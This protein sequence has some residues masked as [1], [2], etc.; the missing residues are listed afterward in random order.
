MWLH[1][2]CWWAAVARWRGGGGG[3]GRG[4]AGR[5]GFT[6]H[7][8]TCASIPLYASQVLDLKRIMEEEH[9]RKVHQYGV[10]TYTQMVALHP[11][12]QDIVKNGQWVLNQKKKYFPEGANA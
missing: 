9:F 5:P 7:T 1:R 2:G 10:R 3:A 11:A 4:G 12:I 6:A 8:P